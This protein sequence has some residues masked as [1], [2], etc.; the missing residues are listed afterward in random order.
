MKKAV[1]AY[2]WKRGFSFSTTVVP[3]TI[4]KL[5]KKSSYSIDDIKY[6]LLHQA[7]A[8]NG[9]SSKKMNI[10]TKKFYKNIH[11]Y[12]NTSAGTIPIA[13]NEMDKGDY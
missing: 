7:N 13:L 9:G 11:N 5:L 2:E 10:D 12:G 6:F 1:Y 4:E 3:Q 8:R